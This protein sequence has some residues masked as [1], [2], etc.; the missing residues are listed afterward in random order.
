MK[1]SVKTTTMAVA[2]VAAMAAAAG[3]QALEQGMTQ[4][5]RQYV[6]GG[7]SIEEASMLEAQRLDYRLWLLTVDK[8]SGA[9]LA[10]AMASIR[11]NQDKVV[12]NTQLD[13]PYLLVDLAPGRYAIEVTLEGKTQ[14]ST[15]VIAERGLRQVIARFDTGAEVSPDMPDRTLPMV[16][17]VSLATPVPDFQRTQ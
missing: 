15:V 5:S 13:G 16:A 14:R 3:A 2:V 11:N 4:Q 1:H 12:L 17:A 6:S 7:V 8:K 10:G 9:W